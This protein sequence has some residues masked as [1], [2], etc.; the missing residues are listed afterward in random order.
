[1]NM[2]KNVGMWQGNCRHAEVIHKTTSLQGFLSLMDIQ[3]N[4][5]GT[6]IV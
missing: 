6:I 4:N 3:V 5:I 1:M 2:N